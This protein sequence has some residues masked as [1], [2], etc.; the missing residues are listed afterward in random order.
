MV[1]KY[2]LLYNNIYRSIWN[3]YGFWIGMEINY[4]MEWLWIME[5]MEI[6]YG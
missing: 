6:N 5:P 1:N 3:G 4:G 2:G